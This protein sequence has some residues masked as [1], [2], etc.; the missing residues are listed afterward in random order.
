[1]EFWRILCLRRGVV[2]H[3][4]EPTEPK[5]NG[6]VTDEEYEEQLAEYEKNKEIYDEAVKTAGH[7]YT[8]AEA[9][10]SEDY[11]TVTFSALQCSSV[12]PERA[13]SLDLLIN[14]AGKYPVS[15]TLDEAVTGK[16]DN[17]RNRGNLC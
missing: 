11:T 2:F 7:T 5:K 10:W 15:V 1:M 12:C 17:C 16:F 9:K 6:Y 13:N 14:T 3:I 8:A 4:S